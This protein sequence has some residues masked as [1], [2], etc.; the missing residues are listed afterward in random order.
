MPTNPFDTPHNQQ[1]KPPAP[2]S[3][4][5]PP[6]YPTFEA[7]I[8][9]ADNTSAD[10]WFAHNNYDEAWLD[11]AIAQRRQTVANYNPNAPFD[12]F[13]NNSGTAAY[14]AHL[15][16]ALLAYKARVYP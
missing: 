4:T 10:Y 15:V 14:A 2:V 1:D 16:T 7:S 12:P 6:T 5:T 11:R 9:N 8:L 13:Q 3:R